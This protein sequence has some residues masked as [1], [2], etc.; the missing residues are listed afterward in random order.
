MMVAPP[1]TI[2]TFPFSPSMLISR[3]SGWLGHR[4]TIT[5]ESAGTR[6]PHFVCRLSM[7]YI[8]HPSAVSLSIAGYP[9]GE[10]AMRK[11]AIVGAGQSGLQLALGLLQK[12]YE[13]TVIS[14]RTPEQVLNGRVTSSQF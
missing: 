10:K 8:W 12:G 9:G 7:V 2:E 3:S 1:V 14:N 11:I 13:V 5:L 4:K 6:V